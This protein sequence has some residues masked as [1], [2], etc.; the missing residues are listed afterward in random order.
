MG[1]DDPRRRQRPGLPPPRERGRADPD[2]AA[3]P[4]SRGSGCTT[5]C[6][7]IARREDGQVGRATSRC[8]PRSSTGSGRDALVMLFA[9]GHYR[10]PM[11]F[12]DEHA[13][14]GAARRGADPRGRARGWSTAP[15]PARHGPAPRRFFA[16]LADDFN[17]PHALGAAVRLGPRGQPAH[18]AGEEVGAPTCARCS[19]CSASTTSLDAARR[20]RRRGA[21]ARGAARPRA[22]RRARRATSPRPTGCAT[23]CAPAGWEV[24]DGP[25]GARA[26]AGAAVILY[27]RNRSARRC[28]PGAGRCRARRGRPRAP[29]ASRGCS[30]RPVEVAD[31]DEIERAAPARRPPGDLRADA[32]GYPYADA[33]RAAR[34]RRA[35][36]RR[37][38]RG[39][40][41]AEP[42]R[43]RPHGRGRGR[44]RAGDP[45]APR[46]EVTPAAARRRRARSSTC[47]SPACATSPTSWARPRPRGCWCYGAAGR[48][49]RRLRRA[50]LR[51]RRRAGAGRRGKGCARGWPARA[52]TLVSLPLRG[53]IDSLNVERRRRRARCTGSLQRRRRVLTALHNCG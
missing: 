18:R 8:C 51:R 49:R 2:G 36:D 34:R 19:A 10:Q 22:R 28:G 12:A 31:A 11:A 20:R 25:G 37:A 1:F 47:R 43:D 29:P 17:T 32:G 46:A 23:S 14:A 53:R 15:S 24:R 38:R 13:R 21:E 5:G 7:Q 9:G 42:R 41:P 6:S 27:G 48:G 3:A 4:S 45:R 35:A 39:P 44:D 52:T 30:R 40:G 33:A 26:G 50:R 16:A